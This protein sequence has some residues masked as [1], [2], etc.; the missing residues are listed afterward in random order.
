MTDVDEADELAKQLTDS[1][2]SDLS[3][4]PE[5]SDGTVIFRA[6]NGRIFASIENGRL[7][8]VCGHAALEEITRPYLRPCDTRP[9][10][11]VSVDLNGI[12]KLPILRSIIDTGYRFVTA[13]TPMDEREEA[14]R[15]EYKNLTGKIR[16]S[17]PE[18]TY[19]DE[20]LFPSS[21][22][23]DSVPVPKRIRE[24]R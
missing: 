12:V 13:R 9:E 15:E 5:E 18:K 23:K 8:A 10:T 22:V 24:M 17:L 6:P 7:D 3:V 2:A 14:V 16:A 11:W 1:I 4:N 20:V 21:L 19:T